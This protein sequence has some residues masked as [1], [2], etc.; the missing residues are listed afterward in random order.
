[1]PS[2]VNDLL[3]EIQAALDDK[4][5]GLYLY[6]SL[7]TGDFDETVSDID[8]LAALTEDLTEADFQVLNAIHEQLVR[9]NPA[10][11]DR[12]EIAYLSTHGLKTFK[13]Q[14]TKLGIISPGEPFHIID[15]G[16][17]WLMNWYTVQEK[18][19]TLYGPPPQT[20]IDPTTRDEYIEA[21]RTHIKAWQTYDLY[22][23][24]VSHRGAQ[25]YAILT[26]CRGLYTLTYGEPTSKI[27]AAAWAAQQMPAWADL[28][29]AALI[30]RQN[31]RDENI[32]HLAT[33]DET[34]RF[35]RFVIDLI[36]G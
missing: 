24:T 6:G 18:G 19:R 9:D 26:M 34:R 32:D 7:V 1:M 35:V 12:I 11:R 23:E 13:T 2:L 8:L 15:A 10:W 30:W 25:A 29:S 21:V 28:I 31:W 5:V 14:T 22:S 33:L 20:L 17:D 4:L 36:E 27:K 3:T 16:K